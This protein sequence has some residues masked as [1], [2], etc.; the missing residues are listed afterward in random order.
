M[1]LSAPLDTPGLT[2]IQIILTN[3]KEKGI[4]SI[5]ISNMYMYAFKSFDL[6]L[7]MVHSANFL[8]IVFHQ[9]IYDNWHMATCMH[10]QS[11]ESVENLAQKV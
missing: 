7:S 1:S 2:C 11:D 4:F 10:C 3:L 5:L 9:M 6:I 8:K